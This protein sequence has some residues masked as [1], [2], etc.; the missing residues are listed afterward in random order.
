VSKKTM[1][2][3]ACGCELQRERRYNQLTGEPI[4]FIAG[5]FRRGAKGQAL[6]LSAVEAI[7]IQEEIAEVCG[8]TGGRLGDGSPDPVTRDNYRVR[9]I[10][11]ETVRALS[12]SGT[13]RRIVLDRCK[14]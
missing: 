7:A 8:W 14:R 2:V 1:D 12:W 9:N 13:L 4:R 5:H 3:C 11:R 6:T 10:V